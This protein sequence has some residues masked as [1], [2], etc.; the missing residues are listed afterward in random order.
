VAA[1]KG[2]QKGRAE[3][4]GIFDSRGNLLERRTLRTRSTEETE[5]Y[6]KSL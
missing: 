6:V 4:L 5:D 2:I 1:V 3:L